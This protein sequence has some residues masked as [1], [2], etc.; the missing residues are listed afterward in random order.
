LPI[1]VT[2]SGIV[3]FSKLLQRPK[4]F[5][6]MELTPLGMVHARQLSASPERIFFDGCDR[7][8][9]K[10]PGDDQLA[11]E[12]AVATHHDCLVVFDLERQ[13]TPVDG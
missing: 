5:S 6:A 4:A 8:S 2:L 7:F 11:R 9:L 1:E 12:L 3:I 13:W 10:L